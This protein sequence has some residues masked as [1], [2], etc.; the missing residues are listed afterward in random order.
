M[1]TGFVKIIYSF[2]AKF[3]LFFAVVFF[4][5]ESYAAIDYGT[6]RIRKCD[7]MTGEVEGLQYNPF[8]GGDDVE[9]I[10]S[11]PVC[12]AVA[13][14]AYGSTK[15]AIAAMNYACGNPNGIRVVPSPFLDAID[16]TKAAINASDPKCATGIAGA[17]TSLQ[18]TASAFAI[19]W[20]VSKEVFNNARICGS[21]WKGPNPTQYM[22]NADQYKN[23]VEKTVDGYIERQEKDKLKLSNKSYREWY[24]G[25]V[26]FEDNSDDETC[27]DVTQ[28]KVDG[29]YP[30]QKYYMRG[31]ETGNFD[32]KKYYITLNNDPSSLTRDP[33][34]ITKALTEDRLKDYKKAYECCKKRAREY[35]CIEY[36]ND[37]K[38]CRVGSRC[39]ITSTHP[40]HFSVKSEDNGRMACVETYS[41]CP[42][43]FTLGGGASKCIYY[44]DGVEIS[45]GSEN[46]E[47]IKLQDIKNGNCGG[48]SEIRNA[49]CT[50]NN[51]AGRCKNYCQ[52]MAH[53]TKTDLSNYQYISGLSS[54]YFSNAC[55]N[56]TGDSR[57]RISYGTGFIAGSSRHFSAPL[58]QC[59]KETLENVFYNR[60]GHTKC[61]SEIDSINSQ[62]QCSKGEAYKQGQQVSSRS[63]FAKMQDL[64]Q[65]TVKM[66][67]TLSIVFYGT[68]LLFIGKD[69]VQKKDLLMYIL[70]IGLVLYFATGDAWQTMFFDGIYSSST[71]FS[72][73]VF[74]IETS[75]D[76][77]KRD[78]CQF[79]NLTLSDGSQVLTSEPYPSGK[80]YLAIWDSLDC[81]IARYMGFGP[82]VSTANI[83]KLMIAGFFTGAPGIY[84]AIALLIFGLALI[85]AT[86]IALHIF[87]SSVISV[88]ILV[89]VSPLVIP[90]A[91]FAKTNNIFKGWLTQLISFCFQPMILFAYIAIFITVMDK[92]LIGSAKFYGEPPARIISC[93]QFCQNS[94]GNVVTD[95]PN[96][97]RPGEK[98]IRPKVDSVACMITNDSFGTWP[99]FELLGIGIP[100]LLDFMTDHAREKILTILKAALVM[101]FLMEFMEQIPAIATALLGGAALPGAKVS[102]GNMFKSTVG[103]L[104]GVQQRANRAGFKYAPKLAKGTSESAK[105]IGQSFNLGKQV[106][107]NASP[108]GTST[109]GDD[110]SGG[111]TGGG[112]SGGGSTGGGGSGGSSV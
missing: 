10:M 39:K 63:F 15:I 25:G 34:D 106:S 92:T 17:T 86:L 53:C 18:L 75:E 29:Q 47:M 103:F 76:L 16:I 59:V 19:L 43:N 33:Q 69:G 89:Y 71:F 45:A 46:Y 8:Y 54:P 52:F 24:Y 110:G 77:N 112:G 20:G 9:F 82:E 66:V 108:S 64:M 104:S 2:I 87:L 94:I 11:N 56:F 70:K 31:F 107:N 13:S 109:A 79:G 61:V 44:K 85:A 26:E 36:G 83:A 97:D 51:K 105:K 27:L 102:P 55:V 3:L 58:A 35:A 28:P 38:F 7:P 84:F 48:K 14:Y 12:I 1:K 111:S 91:L 68:K 81:K 95:S 6:G 90:C 98:I 78:G 73:L 67:L 22:N 88:I 101:Y 4:A 72:N 30:A 80:E 57:N 62:G 100:F 93:K 37:H 40:V 49:D 21:N 41:L 60:A 23:E 32:C 65:A 96:C 74:K 99:G 50:Y 42:Y 5:L